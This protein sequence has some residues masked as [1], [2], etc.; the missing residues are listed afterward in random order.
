MR[1]HSEPAAK[2]EGETGDEVGQGYLGNHS[3]SIFMFIDEIQGNDALCGTVGFQSQ[4]SP[5]RR[6]RALT[7]KTDAKP[8]AFCNCRK[9]IFPLPTATFFFSLPPTDLP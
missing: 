2:V 6:D 1:L 8:K 3:A 7:L 4:T 5:G 9:C